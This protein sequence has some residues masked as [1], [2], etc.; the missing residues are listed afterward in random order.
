MLRALTL[1]TESPEGCHG[2]HGAVRLPVLKYPSGET[3]SW[4][5]GETLEPQTWKHG[6]GLEGGEEERGRYKEGVT[7]RRDRGNREWRGTEGQGRRA[8]L[9]DGA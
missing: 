9:R 4:L 2:S 3:G 5:A 6:R 7:Q 1:S 8:P